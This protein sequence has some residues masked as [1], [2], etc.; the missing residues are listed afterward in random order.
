MRIGQCRWV[1]FTFAAFFALSSFAWAAGGP[2]KI[3]YFELPTV[4]QQSQWGKKSSEEFKQQGERI[5]A[6]VDEKAKAF[7]TAKEDFDKQ[8]AVMDEKTRTKKT[9]EIQALQQEGERLLTESNAKLND[10]SQKLT[11]PIVQ[12]VL[13][14]VTKIGKDDKY[15]FIFEREK[16]GI[17]F[18]N[19]KED[20]TKRVI[21]E[22]DKASPK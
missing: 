2:Q 7:R 8:K 18:V 13:E 4:L 6:D 17:V 1:L 11:S 16:A 3:G 21:T 20:L 12:K 19:E 14:I 5:K 9:G 10:L 22:L 15:D